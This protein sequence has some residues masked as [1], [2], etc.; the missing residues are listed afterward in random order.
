M[1]TGE[2][3][4]RIKQHLLPCF[5]P[6][7]AVLCFVFFFPAFADFRKVNDCELARLNASLTGQPTTPSDEAECIEADRYTVL[8]AEW[9]P[10]ANGGGFFSVHD[11]YGYDWLQLQYLKVVGDPYYEAPAASSPLSVKAGELSVRIGLGS[12]EVGFDSGDFNVSCCSDAT[13]ACCQK[14]QILGTIHLDGLKVKTNESSYI[15][16]TITEGQTRL[17]VKL[18]DVTIDRISLATLS[19]GDADGFPGAGN[20]S[21]AGYVGLK[22]TYITNVTVSGSLAVNVGR[23]DKQELSITKFVHTGIDNL[24]VGISSLDTTVVLGDKKD[25]SGTRYVLGTLYMKDLALNVRGYLDIYNPADRNIATTLEFGLNVP[26]L[27]LDTLAWGDIDGLT[28]NTKVDADGNPIA[29][30][31]ATGSATTTQGWV[32][33]RNLAINNLA[34]AGRLTVEAM[35]VQAGNT[36]I[37]PLPV[38]IALV[39]MGFSNLDIRMDSLNTDVALGNRKDNLNQVLG[40]IYL[41]GFHMAINGNVDIHTLS[42]SSQGIV[43]DLNVNFST[44]AWQ[45]LSW[46]DA[47]GVSGDKATAGFR[48]W[49]NFSINGLNLAGRVSLDVATVDS[50]VIPL[51][52]DAQM[53]S[54][55]GTKNMSPTFVHFGIGTGNANDTL[56]D[57]R[58]LSVGIGSLTA[59]V[60]LDSSRSLNS[61]HAGVLRTLYIGG[62]TA[63]INGWIDIGAH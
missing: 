27:K 22:D 33:L 52:A 47:D 40:S 51:S 36:G 28:N 11:D 8:P 24:D 3:K 58:T 54:V 61:P 59:D 1:R 41:G 12:Q 2:I 14:D 19:W 43:L 42:P 26:S 63:K 5:L 49:R 62:M 48:G 30:N 37:Y 55:Y 17:G 35:C 18:D 6:V 23:D 15:T 32:G 25:F 44:F 46:G 7:I 39:R 38:G 4:V 57:T 21:K 10:S 16:M 60:V 50:T 45:S 9:D 53:Y 20:T 34:I 56:T 31:L 29:G 13:S